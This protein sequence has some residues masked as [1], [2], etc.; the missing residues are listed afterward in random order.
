MPLYEYACRSCGQRF[1][2]MRPVAARL[3][4]PSCVHCGEVRTTLALSA[5]GFVGAAAPAA[6]AGGACDSRPHGGC[7]GGVCR[8]H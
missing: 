7:C 6:Q 4:P 1:E 3:D 8:T 5:P 2:L